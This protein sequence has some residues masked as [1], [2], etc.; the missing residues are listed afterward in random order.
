ML[1]ESVPIFNISNSF[2]PLTIYD[3]AKL[4]GENLNVPV[5]R[6]LKNSNV[7]SAPKVVKVHPERFL[8]I[9]PNYKFISIE[10]GLKNVCKISQEKFLR[11]ENQSN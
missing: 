6:G 2:E 1:K 10:E 5:K 4:I 7:Y 9:F 3:L 8:N 11:N